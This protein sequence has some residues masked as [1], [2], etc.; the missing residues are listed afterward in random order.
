M[1][2]KL[3][4]NKCS[5][6]E[7]HE[8]RE[9]LSSSN[10]KVIL[11]DI[12]KFYRERILG[13]K[14]ERKQSNA[15][16]EGS[17]MHT[18]I[19]EPDLKDVEYAFFNGWQKRGKEYDEFVSEEKNK[20]KIILSAPQRMKCN[21]LYE[22]YL[23]RKEAVNLIKGGEPEVSICGIISGIKLKARFDYV[24][25]EKGY[26]VDVKTTG[27]DSGLEIFKLTFKDLHYDLSAAL[28]LDIAEQYYKKNFDFYFIVLSKKDMECNVYKLS[29]TS[30]IY[31]RSLVVQAINKYKHCSE[32][33]NWLEDSDVK[34]E[35]DYFIEEV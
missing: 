32:T 4:I 3:G 30:R 31:G 6:R 21:K 25:E 12:Q 5:N 26:I 24:N 20:N 9:Y 14:E 16:D 13:E 35:T 8:D 11:N 33:G 7:Y 17:F 29:K 23:S 34:E 19:L 27:F 15:L 1:S 28:Y 2:L 10:L 18:M 22:S